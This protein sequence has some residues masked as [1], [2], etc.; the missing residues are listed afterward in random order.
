[1]AKARAGFNH[2]SQ[3][4]QVPVSP[5]HGTI[6]APHTLP[7]GGVRSRAALTPP[8]FDVR[9]LPALNLRLTQ[10]GEDYCNPDKQ[11]LMFFDGEN[12]ARF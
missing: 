9:V 8:A 4:R 2:S 6:P 12:R 10:I 11:F 5:A 7:M 3:Q 1:V